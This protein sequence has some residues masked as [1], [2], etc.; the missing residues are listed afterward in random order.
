MTPCAFRFGSPHEM[1][2]LL[3]DM[4][5]ALRAGEYSPDV[6]TDGAWRLLDDRA[7]LRHPT[8]L[9]I[10]F[11]SRIASRPDPDAAVAA[12][13]SALSAPVGTPSAA[14]ARILSLPVPPKGMCEEEHVDALMR[15]AAVTG[16]VPIPAD[17]SALVHAPSPWA[18]MRIEHVSVARFRED[19]P[20]DG[21]AA[22][23]VPVCVH[24]VWASRIEGGSDVPIAGYEIEPFHV[25]VRHDWTP[26]PMAAMRT[27]LLAQAR[28]AS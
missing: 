13:I 15:I 14:E 25:A 3:P 5:V 17:A 4:L 1:D 22:R 7:I 8:L 28:D 12:A 16:S 20:V 11:A 27:L 10:R 9:R 24:A 26:E 19:A 6:R 18:P 2:R 21:P 23:H